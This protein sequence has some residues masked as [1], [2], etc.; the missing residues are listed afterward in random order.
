MPGIEGVKSD[1]VQSRQREGGA[2]SNQRLIEVLIMSIRHH[3]IGQTTVRLVHTKLCAAWNVK[4]KEEC[5]SCSVH[6]DSYANL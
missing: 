6:R 3:D 1:D 5:Q 4:M 2:I